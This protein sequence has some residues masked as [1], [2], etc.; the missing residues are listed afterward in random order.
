MINYSIYCTDIISDI[1]IMQAVKLD[2]EPD[3][4][5]S[6][7]VKQGTVPDEIRFEEECYSHIS[8]TGCFLSNN[9]CFLYIPDGNTIIYEM[10]P[11]PM[12]PNPINYIIGWGISMAMH[13]R[14]TPVVHCSALKNDNGAFLISGSSG[15]GKSTVTTSLINAGM[16]F[17][18]D[19]TSSVSI[20]KETRT[21]YAT[22][23]YPFRK[24]CRG[25][26]QK[27]D[28]DE[29]DLIYI[30]ED[31][32]KFL[33]PYDG[34]YKTAPVPVKAL[35]YIERIKENTDA[36]SK[37][38]VTPVLGFEK[39][40]YIFKSLFLSKLFKPSQSCPYLFQMCLDLAGII[41]IYVVTRP[42][43]GDTRE[44]IFNEIQKIISNS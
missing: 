27:W 40:Q 33:V 42:A 31:K 41:P 5:T 18:A 34:E 43:D 12:Y 1:E 37:V 26:V 19:D 11:N 17:M 3:P 36:C 24:L 32:D 9:T 25:E 7:T 30:D 35:I 8:E 39:V 2:R 16:K 29:N 44:E 13:Q 22:P 14:G 28:L 23:C 6:I 4:L 15:S 20:N 38:T 21:V 10:K